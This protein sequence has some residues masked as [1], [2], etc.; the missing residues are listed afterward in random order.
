MKNWRAAVAAMLFLAAG[1]GAFAAAP[2]ATSLLF[3]AAPMEKLAPGTVIT[4]RYD[5]RSADPERLGTAFSDDIRVTVEAEADT[6][7]GAGEKSVDVELFTGPRRRQGGTFPAMAGNPLLIVFLETDAAALQKLTGG[8][9][10]YI[11]N[12][13]RAA[14]RDGATVEPVTVTVDGREIAAE[15]VTIAPFVDDPHRREF[16][17]FAGKR[18]EF[19]VADTVPGGFVSLK[20][21]TDGEKP[22]EVYFEEEIRYLRAEEA[23]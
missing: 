17:R 3:E 18:Y 14:F 11:K 8:N 12:R 20:S 6:A 13:I 21:T 22:G 1:G 23:R 10:R 4:Y 16:G 9:A 2:T 7:A 15:K 19:V 5:R